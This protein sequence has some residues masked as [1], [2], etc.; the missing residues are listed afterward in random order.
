MPCPFFIILYIFQYF[1]LKCLRKFSLE[2]EGTKEGER[3]G[4]GGGK[5]GGRS[6][7]LFYCEY[8]KDKPASLDIP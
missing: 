7:G 1:L 3:R 4:E 6:L 5:E 8:S 2:A